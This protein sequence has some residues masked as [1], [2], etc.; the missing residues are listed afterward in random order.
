MSKPRTLTPGEIALVRR[1]ARRERILVWVLTPL[2]APL[3]F[4]SV[5]LGVASLF[6]EHPDIFLG[7]M[8]PLSGVALIAYLAWMWRSAHRYGAADERT[9]VTELRGVFSVRFQSRSHSL[10]IGETCVFVASKDIRKQ[11]VPGKHCVVEAIWDS[12]I[13]VVAV[14]SPPPAGQKR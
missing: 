9:E 12:P 10:F 4:L 6:D 13:L 7:V 8:F 5:V 2:A 11:L 3:G 14:R 1:W